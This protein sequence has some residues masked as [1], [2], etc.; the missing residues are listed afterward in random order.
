MSSIDRQG[1]TRESP[2]SPLAGI[3]VL[4]FGAPGPVAHAG[5]TF[6]LLGADVVRIVRPGTKKPSPSEG[7]RPRVELDLKK[8][9]DLDVARDL[10]ARADVLIEG[11]RPG[12]MDRIGLGGETCCALNRGLVYVRVS[13]WG[14]EGKLAQAAGH[15][16]NYVAASGLLSIMTPPGHAGFVPLPVLADIAG[17]AHMVVVA[18]L[19]GLIRRSTQG[20]GI[21]DVA[22]IDGAVALTEPFWSRRT[23]P[24]EQQPLARPF[25]RTYVTADGAQLAVACIEEKFYARFVD[26]LG[27]VARDLP[28]RSDS[29]NWARL[30]AL[31][32][33]VIQKRTLA[34]WHVVFSELD[35]CVS[36]VMTPDEARRHPH[37]TS[38]G[39]LP[40]TAAGHVQPRFPIRF[41]GAVAAGAVGDED[42]R[43]LGATEVLAAW[44]SES[45]AG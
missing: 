39:L 16:L 21:A 42:A 4:E 28:D 38:R 30:T 2:L 24:V 5:K 44:T 3:K 33:D 13:G 15:D 41:D 8:E 22:M 1:V 40:A 10:A 35:A 25:Y 6:G 43:V 14:R 32:G 27:L 9:A 31:F 18:A 20:G 29:R 26:G 23:R 17:G 19:T 36:P 12:V 7:G 11:F 45:D 37:I 34:E